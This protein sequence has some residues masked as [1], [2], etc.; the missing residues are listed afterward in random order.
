M[1]IVLVFLLSLFTL[2]SEIFKK[3]FIF[4]Q[5]GLWILIMIGIVMVIIVSYLEISEKTTYTCYIR[6]I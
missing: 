6:H 5:N 4:L 3:S 2:Y 1:V